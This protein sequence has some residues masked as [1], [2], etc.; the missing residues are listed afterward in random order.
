MNPNPHAAPCTVLGRFCLLLAQ[1]PSLPFSVSSAVLVHACVHTL[2]P[3]PLWL[4]LPL[5]FLF[6]IWISI[7]SLFLLLFNLDSMDNLWVRK[8]NR[9]SGTMRKPGSRLGFSTCSL[10]ARTRRSPLETSQKPLVPS[11][12]TSAAPAGSGPYSRWQ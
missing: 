12:A 9:P 3:T 4:F 7:W 1:W 5:S 8:M 6:F 10:P 2:T 11:S